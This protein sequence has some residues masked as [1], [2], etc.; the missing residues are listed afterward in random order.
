MSSDYDVIVLG[1]GAAGEHCAALVER[2]L[3][4]GEC[5]YWACIP[6]KPLLRPAKRCMPGATRRRARRSTSRSRWPGATST[7]RGGA[8]CSMTAIRASH[9]AARVDQ[10]RPG[11]YGGMR[12]LLFTDPATLAAD[13]RAG[14]A[15]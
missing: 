1:G 14:P 11:R 3:V 4:G 6:S 15:R 2:E 9:T 12:A 8:N 13:L 5:S 10:A 7:N